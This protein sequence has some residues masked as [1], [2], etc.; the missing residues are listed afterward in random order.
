MNYKESINWLFDLTNYEVTKDSFGKQDATTLAKRRFD[1]SRVFKILDS[2]GSPQDT[3]LII[4]IAGTK[5]KGTTAALLY[6]V[7]TANGYNTGLF[8][9]PHLH[10]IRERIRVNGEIL[11]ESEF[12]EVSTTV[13]SVVENHNNNNPNDKITTFE[14]LTCMAFVAFNNNGTDIQIIETGL[15][16]RLDSTNVVKS[17]IVGI[18]SISEDHT[19]IL[20][21]SLPEIASE[22]FGIVKNGV[23]VVSAPQDSSVIPLLKD[24]C[25]R[26]QASLTLVG[27]DIDVSRTSNSM[28]GQEFRVWGYI[29]DRP[30]DHALRTNLL[31]EYQLENAA[32]AIGILERIRDR[33]Y[34]VAYDK[35]LWGFNNVDWPGRFEI[36]KETP[37]VIADG[38]HNPYSAMR[39]VEALAIDFSNKPV[40]MV[41]G[42]SED[43]DGGA[44][45]RELS[46]IAKGVVVTKSKHPRSMSTEK[47]EDFFW[48]TGIPVRTEA[49]IK[50]AIDRALIQTPQDGI[51]LI[52]GSLFVVAEAREYLLEIDS[53]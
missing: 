50:S 19:E 40:Q 51:V 15:G 21:E 37:L 49:T 38:A 14:A 18:T 45:A 43:K 36:L 16:G 1:L 42:M 34:P 48:E 3:G 2:L 28:L 13:N 25:D 32:V 4:H 23:H 10:S 7:L 33:G 27:K 12:A 8:T 39:L 29:N 30:I 44:M 35:I 52:T 9:S 22:K 20:G 17:S 41:V 53:G 26:N 47:L 46:Q 24:V 31:G 11:T 6:T 5:G